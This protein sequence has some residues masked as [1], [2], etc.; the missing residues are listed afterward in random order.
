MD[1]R[2]STFPASYDDAPPELKP[3][4]VTRWTARLADPACEHDYRLHR[5]PDDRRRALLLMALVAIAGLL[6]LLVEIYI[7]RTG[8]GTVAGLIPPVSSTFLPLVGLVV[9]SR[10][11]SPWTLELLMILSAS[12]GTVTRLSMLTLHPTMTFMWPTAMVGIIFVIYLYLPI[13]FVTSVALAGAFSVVAPAWWLASQGDMLPPDVFYR[14]LIWVTLANAL[15]FIAA[16][17]LQ[18]SLRQQYAQGLVLQELLSTDAMTGIANRRRF[19]GELEREWRRCARSGAPLS[20]LMIDVDH[21][22]AYNDHCGHPQGDACLRQVARLLLDSAGRP[23]DLVARYGGEEFICL[24]PEI[25]GAGA[26]AVASKLAAAL[27]EADIPHPRSPFGPRLTISIG[28]ATAN[29]LS[30][31]PR[32]LVAFADELLY[33]AK[34]AGRNQI[35]VG[36]LGGRSAPARAA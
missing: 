16:N 11:R 12:V 2:L 34:A 3:V 20:L 21:F 4:A 26:L 14:G 15:A 27:R 18:R 9:I 8:V 32:A 22:K 6:N 25:G 24:L 28:V 29:D 17:C 23:G 19:D 36:Q 13:G 1:A 30:G 33:A 7:Y 5:F 35:K 31:A 10:V